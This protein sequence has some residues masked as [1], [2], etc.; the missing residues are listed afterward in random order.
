MK[1]FNLFA[2][3]ALMLVATTLVGTTSCIRLRNNIESGDEGSSTVTT[4][5]YNLS[6]FDELDLSGVG[7]VF[8]TQGNTFSVKV[9]ARE[10]DFKHIKLKTDGNELS[11]STGNLEDGKAFSFGK[12]SGNN[13]GNVK[14]YVTMPTLKSIDQSGVV[15]LNIE[16]PIKTDRL[17]LDVS[18]V[19]NTSI[20]GLIANRFSADV[21]GVGNVSIKQ[22]TAKESEFD[23]SGVGN[24][25]VEYNH[26]GVSKVEVSG[27][28]SVKL[29][30]TLRN[31]QTNGGD[32]TSRISNTTQ[33]IK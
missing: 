31:L 10:K 14:V 2:A 22:L 4:K 20:N 28:G 24:V 25:N 32:I 16:R 3:S 33:I 26:S 29:S 11:F 30:G 23:V 15:N 12:N 27:V 1:K 17:A 9:S 18:G 19:G 7:T 13:M 8:V 5:T 21:S 6:G